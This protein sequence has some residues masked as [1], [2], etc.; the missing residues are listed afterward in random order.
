MSKELDKEITAALLKAGKV[1][2]EN[3]RHGY[4][5]PEKYGHAC[6]CGFDEMCKNWIKAEGDYEALR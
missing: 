5:C 2:F 6:N 4:S 1:L 3:S